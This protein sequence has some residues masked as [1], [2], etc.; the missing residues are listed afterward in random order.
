MLICL[1]S[2]IEH[3]FDKYLPYEVALMALVPF[4]ELVKSKCIQC[5]WQGVHS[6]W[7]AGW[8]LRRSWAW[9]LSWWCL[10]ENIS[11]KNLIFC[12]TEKYKLSKAACFSRVLYS[13]E[14]TTSTI[15]PSTSQECLG[16]YLENLS[17]PNHK[18][19]LDAQLNPAYS[20]ALE[21]FPM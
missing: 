4:F 12:W 2:Y 7:D 18:C 13:S 19:W 10:D 15:N 16:I 5:L 21:E 14:E 1:K 8:P 17:V 11:K 6:G 3:N 20:P 9:H